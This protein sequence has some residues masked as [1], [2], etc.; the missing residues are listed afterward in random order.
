MIAYFMVDK[1]VTKI[2]SSFGILFPAT[3]YLLVGLY[4]MIFPILYDVSLF[5]LLLLSV[6]CMVTGVGLLLLKRWSLWLGLALSPY[7]VVAAWVALS[8]SRNFVGFFPNIKT[9]AFHISLILWIVL[10]PISIILLMDK[11]KKFG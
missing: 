6:I 10:T 1:K 4:M 2:Q 5:A 7:I 11:R 8:Y 9:G 3:F